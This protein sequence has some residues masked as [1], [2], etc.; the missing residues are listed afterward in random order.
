MKLRVAA[1]LSIALLAAGAWGAAPE[2]A[3]LPLCMAAGGASV[4]G[5]ETE[6]GRSTLAEPARSADERFGFVASYSS[7][8]WS[9]DLQKYR[10]LANGGRE[11][12]WSARARLDGQGMARRV[13]TNREGALV[14]LQWEN[15]QAWQRD[16]LEHNGAGEVDGLGRERL[17][18]LRGERRLEGQGFRRRSTVLGDI[19]NSVPLWLGPPSR[20]AR[21]L[22]LLE[23]PAQSRAY[24]A[25]K[26]THARR[27]AMLY[28]GA[29]DGMLHAFDAAS[30]DEVFAF[31]PSAV[32]AR[33]GRLADPSYAG[34]QHRY[35]V[36]GPLLAEDVY[37]GGVWHSVLVGSLGGGGRALFALDVTEPRQPRLLWEIAADARYAGL[38]FVLQR[39]QIV[40][41]ADGR[42][43]LLVGNGYASATQR[44]VLYLID[45][46]S[47]RQLRA[48][49]ADEGSGRPNGLSGPRA[50]DLDG[51]GIVERAYAGDLQGN[52]WR[53]DLA[54]GAATAQIAFGGRP[55]FAARDLAGR[56]QAI[57][58]APR[59][60]RHPSGNG[61]LLL[62]G[63]G[64][65]FEAADV[66]PGETNMSLYGIWDRQRAESA[67]SAPAISR[68]DLLRQVYTREDG[69]G[70]RSLSRQPLTW[71][72]EGSTDGARGKLGWFLELP[73]A[74]ERLLSDPQSSGRLA[75]FNSLTPDCTNG[76]VSRLLAVDPYTGGA[77]QVD[78]LDGNR[79]G[80][81]DGN[82]RVGDEVLASLRI[83]AGPGGLAFGYD[84]ASGL[85]FALGTA[86]PVRFFDGIRPGRQSWRVMEEGR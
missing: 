39:P 69:Q 70:R 80:L 61:L 51:D 63:T 20:N 13:L 58:V 12:L 14:E 36:D 67:S 86:E 60:I 17:A 28:V 65:F 38:G 42:W 27:P 75:L 37:F 24:S 1:V 55:L 2:I 62:F 57:S 64:R 85:G 79:D 31:V 83:A 9:G 41:L 7:A 34:M 8:D 33:L 44:A 82:D 59:A 40:R 81:I 76:H 32:F 66:L 22:D 45:V 49:H 4:S 84:L 56:A 72:A 78:A 16:A 77:P 30:G 68:A 6:S 43:S 46:A 52:L 5:P 25:F 19:V 10:L 3:Q 73:V 53:F 50:V 54:A 35:F 15:L 11:A 26:Q 29:N 21:A 74:G 48:L 47:G 23:G 71:R 18:F